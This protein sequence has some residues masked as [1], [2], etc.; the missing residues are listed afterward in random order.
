V[1]NFLQD[2]RFGLRTLA[3][4]PGFTA[5]AVLTLALGIGANSALFSVVNGVLLNPLPYPE[6]NRLLAVYAK[7]YG[8]DQASVTYLN[9]LDWQKE[10]SSLSGMAAFRNEELILTGVGEGERLR[11]Q[12]ISADFFPLLGVRP[13]LGRTFRAEEDQIGGAP[14]AIISAGLWERKFGSAGEILGKSITLSGKSYEIVGVIPAGFTL[15]GNAREAFIPIGQWADPTF[16][17]RHV[18]MGTNALAKLKPG[19]TLAQA[20]ADMDRIA[21]NLAETYPDADKGA[22]INLL[23]LKENMV[24]DIS[25]SL[26]VLLGAVGFLL[27]IACA[28]VANLMLAR[29]TGRTREFAIRA[30]MG[31]SRGRMIRQLLTESVLLGSTGGTLGLGVAYFGTKAIL[32]TMPGV[33][34]RAAEVGLDSHVV[35]FTLGISVVVGVLF[36]LVPALRMSRS[37]LQE[38]LKEGG[39]GSSGARHRAQSVFVAVEMA[40][41]LVLLAGAGLMV[42]SLTALWNVNPGFNPHSVLTFNVTMPRAL[43]GNPQAQRALMREIHSAVLGVPGLQSLS[44]QGGSLPMNGDS[45][46]PFWIEGHPKPATMQDMPFALFYLVEA[47]Y[48]K[49]MGTHLLRGRFLTDQDNEHSHPVV[50]IDEMF[51]RKQF[52]NEDPVGKRLNLAIFGTQA[53][54]VGVAEHV[55]H[56]GLDS[57]AT[58]KIQEQMYI[59]FMQLPDRFMPLLS[60]GIGLVA[61]T[62]GAPGKLVGP[63]R[64]KMMQMNAD[65]VVYAVETMDEIIGEYLA[66]K[67]FSMILLSVFA[68]LAMVLASVGI[69]G[70][71]SYIVGQRTHEIGVRM[72]LGAQRG[73][74]LRLVLGQGT[75]MAAA[76]VGIGLAA[77]I[78]LTRLLTKA[79]LLFSVSARDPLTLAG[80]SLLLTVVALLACY[81]PARRAMKTDPVVALRYE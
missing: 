3:K 2:L 60:N 42:R 55:K 29:A 28:N 48:L 9:F 33:L 17:D 30:A 40:M 79:Q 27:L 77:A 39:R 31:A 52:R 64:K 24:G 73:D 7:A 41:A 21:K 5:I 6:P 46:L 11:G 65:Q 51:A 72:A 80:V 23:S 47:D 25:S 36:G 66:A 22:G 81:V 34:P 1:N 74:V 59:P 57:D 8:F 37:G 56:W 70:V 14:V 76:G 44:M 49:A 43:L 68:G 19:V 26:F 20:Q 12:M 63:I 16:R 35:L 15:Y 4:A 54:I 18:S 10:N 50:V 45:E 58:S 78:G 75:I 32:K 67:R 71:I 38:T 62:Q 53:E 13:V 61:R 69:Y